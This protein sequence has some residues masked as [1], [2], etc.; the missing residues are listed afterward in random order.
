MILSERAV[1]CC[2]VNG[3]YNNTNGLGR[4]TATLHRYR[5]EVLAAVGPVDVHLAGPTPG[6]AMW[7]FDPEILARSRRVADMWGGAVH[8]LS[9]DLAAP[10]WSV[11]VWAQLCVGAADLMRRLR[12]RYRE[13][14]AVA[15]DTPFA[16]LPAVA[17]RESSAGPLRI[18]IG[19]RGNAPGWRPPTDGRRCASPTSAGSSPGISARTTVFCRDGTRRFPPWLIWTIPRCARC[20]WQRPELSR[21]AGRSRWTGRPFYGGSD[22]S[23]EGRGRVPR[24]RGPAARAGARRRDRGADAGTGASAGRL[25]RADHSAPP[26][27]L[28][29]HTVQSGSSLGP[30]PDRDNP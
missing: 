22:R 3:I 28:V 2:T 23:R 24:H 25:P 1:V 20:P 26:A 15:V 18:R 11:P 14:L 9:Y 17:P 19:S 6:P 27:R 30:Q 12:R 13:V 5:D 21:P 16:G 10:F 7:A 29:D 4:Q 8:A